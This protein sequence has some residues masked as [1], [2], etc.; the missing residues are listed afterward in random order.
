MTRTFMSV[1][2]LIFMQGCFVG[3]FGVDEAERGELGRADFYY[4]RFFDRL[5]PKRALASHGAAQ[6][7]DFDYDGGFASVESSDESVVGAA[8]EDA[9]IALTTGAPGAAKITLKDGRGRVIDRIAVAVRDA[10]AVAVTREYDAVLAGGTELWGVTLSSGG[11]ALLGHGAFAVSSSDGVQSEIVRFLWIDNLLA[12]TGPAGEHTV[13]LAAAEASQ[14][15]VLHVVGPEALTAVEASDLDCEIGWSCLTEVV[16]RVGDKRVAG[17]HCGWQRDDALAVR[18]AA[19]TLGFG[20][21]TPSAAQWLGLGAT[22][23]DFTGFAG[24]YE[25]TCVVSGGPS[26]TISVRLKPEVP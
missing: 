22:A 14:D 7:L 8:I 21:P 13:T 9:H 17:V 16:G 19:T 20:A 4:G 11:D 6:E 12:L 10:D 15:E 1:G 3:P 18:L 2:A 26:T 5:S 23:Y 24:E 25:A